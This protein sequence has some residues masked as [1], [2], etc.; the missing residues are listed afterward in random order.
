MMTRSSSVSSF[1]L[2]MPVAV[3]LR[4]GCAGVVESG[5]WV[6]EL[7]CARFRV[8]LPGI[9]VEERWARVCTGTESEKSEYEPA[10]SFPEISA[11]FE[12]GLALTLGGPL[13]PS[14]VEPLEAKS[15]GSGELDTNL[16]LPSWMTVAFSFFPPKPSIFD[17]NA[18]SNSSSSI[19]ASCRMSSTHSLASFSLG[20]CR[21]KFRE[22]EKRPKMCSRL[23]FGSLRV[24]TAVRSERESCL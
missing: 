23:P 13:A 5:I 20:A 8:A 19:L 4:S 18:K 14:L 15:I 1:K 12:I 24:V 11:S 17:P 3:L 16:S 2:P 22:G 10:R 6:V 9:E 21:W 7:A